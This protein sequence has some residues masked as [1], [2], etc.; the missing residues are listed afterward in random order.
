M[1]LPLV[2]KYLVVTNERGR[3]VI[4]TRKRT[5]VDGIFAAGDVITELVLISVCEGAKEA[6]TAYEYLLEKSD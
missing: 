4:D 3:F 1:H 5:S 6:L 2:G